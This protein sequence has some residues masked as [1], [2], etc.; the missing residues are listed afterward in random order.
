MKKATNLVQHMFGGLIPGFVLGILYHSVGTGIPAWI[1]CL[2]WGFIWLLGTIGWEIWQWN[3]S[4]LSWAE[5]MK[6]K[7]TDSILDLVVGN[8]AFL[9]PLIVISCGMYAGN[10][11]RP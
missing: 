10:T 5:Y 7:M 9:L 8:A 6:Y 2:G 11:L 3:N 4:G 1:W